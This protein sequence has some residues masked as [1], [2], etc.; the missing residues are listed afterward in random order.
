MLKTY[1]YACPVCSYQTEITCRESCIDHFYCP[2]C[3]AKM[4]KQ[5][6]APAFTLKGAGFYVNDYKEEK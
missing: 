3:G 2:E 1:D 6:P 4:E 5:F